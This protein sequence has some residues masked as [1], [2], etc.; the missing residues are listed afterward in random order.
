MIAAKQGG[1]AGSTVA[2]SSCGPGDGC[3]VFLG[4]HAQRG[5]AGGL[6]IGVDVEI[7]AVDTAPHGGAPKEA[8]HVRLS[9]V[10]AAGA[11]HAQEVGDAGGAVRVGRH[12]G[13]D[14]VAGH[15]AARHRGR[16]AAAA[17]PRRVLDLKTSTSGF[18]ETLSCRVGKNI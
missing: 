18:K 1:R 10:A 17:E 14:G 15:N 12:A 4:L 11:G 3:A 2:G 7:V 8:A 6:A 16:S 5:D 9:H 13:R